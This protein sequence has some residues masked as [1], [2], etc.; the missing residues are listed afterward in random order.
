MLANIL[1][2]LVFAMRLAQAQLSR[3]VGPITPLESKSYICNVLNY[4]G[5][6]DSK[7]IGPA[8]IDAFQVRVIT[9]VVTLFVN[10]DIFP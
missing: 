6:I 9:H 8:I 10:R 1:S 3:P 7:D 4:G 2:L 5:S